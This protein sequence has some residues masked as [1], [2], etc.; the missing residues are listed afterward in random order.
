MQRAAL[1][2]YDWR[3]KERS[4]RVIRVWHALIT[5]PSQQTFT[6]GSEARVHNKMSNIWSKHEHVLIVQPAVG[7]NKYTAI[8]TFNLLVICGFWCLG[9][10]GRPAVTLPLCHY[11][12]QQM[13]SNNKMDDHE[14]V[15]IWT[16]IRAHLCGICIFTFAQHFISIP[17]YMKK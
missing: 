3:R 11:L 8:N 7:Q 10:T 16:N 17:S 9:F 14:S 1:M 4:H 13:W 15:Q 2:S 5:N 6:Q 12:L